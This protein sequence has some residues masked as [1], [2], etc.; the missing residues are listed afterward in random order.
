MEA[1]DEQ[2]SATAQPQSEVEEILQLAKETSADGYVVNLLIVGCGDREAQVELFRRAHR[3]H[4][5]PEGNITKTT[6]SSPFSPTLLLNKTLFR[7][8]GIDFHIYDA[9]GLYHQSLPSRCGSGLG[10]KHD[11][12][13]WMERFSKF[14]AVI[15]VAD[16]TDYDAITSSPQNSEEKVNP[17]AE[18]TSNRMV[19]ALE[20]FRAISSFCASHNMGTM[21]FLNKEDAFAEKILSSDIAAQPPFADYDGPPH[22]FNS[23]VQYFIQ[24]FKDCCEDDELSFIH[25]TSAIESNTNME[26]I[27]DSTRTILMTAN[28][29]RKQSLKS[30]RQWCR[31]R[32]RWFP[33]IMPPIVSR[34]ARKCRELGR[35]ASGD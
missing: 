22:D 33:L 20:S 34:L 25:V 19:Q 9:T 31:V 24:K 15:F 4:D 23:G 17:D 11:L 18:A 28:L 10:D 1:P 12:P 16:L 13:E 30:S 26:F 32:R 8:D 29:R 3:T 2:P 5:F 7:M 14:D 35:T 6:S 27:L 21:L